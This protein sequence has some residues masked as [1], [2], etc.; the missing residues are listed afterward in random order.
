MAKLVEI[1]RA[2][3]STEERHAWMTRQNPVGSSGSW[4]RFL[5]EGRRPG[6]GGRR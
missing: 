3:M 1:R 6:R 2:V 5:S 4:E